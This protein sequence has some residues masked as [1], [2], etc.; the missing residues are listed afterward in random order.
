MLVLSQL[1]R[2]T[3]LDLILEKAESLHLPLTRTE[4]ENAQQQPLSIK[5]ALE[6]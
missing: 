4:V 3:K 5:D 6:C 1:N 2:V